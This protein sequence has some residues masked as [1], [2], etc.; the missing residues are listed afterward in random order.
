MEIGGAILGHPVDRALTRAGD[1]GWDSLKHMQLIFAVEEKF[2]V[3]FTEE[4]IPQMDSFSRLAD[5]LEQH[6][7]P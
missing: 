7:A 2:G 1:D 5:Y 4:E 3:R 6:H